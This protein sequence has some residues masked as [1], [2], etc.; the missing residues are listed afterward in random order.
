MA[1]AETQLY[2]RFYTLCKRYELTQI[3]GLPLPPGIVRAQST[4]SEWNRAES[5]DRGSFLSN[6][7]SGGPGAT[8]DSV[9]AAA[10]SKS[11]DLSSSHSASTWGIDDTDADWQEHG[12]R[13]QRAGSDTS[14]TSVVPNVHAGQT[15]SGEIQVEQEAHGANTTDRNLLTSKSD[16][17]ELTNMDVARPLNSNPKSVS[18]LVKSR[19]RP[20][21]SNAEA[22]SVQQGQAQEHPSEPDTS[23]VDPATAHDDEKVADTTPSRGSGTSH[24]NGSLTTEGVSEAESTEPATA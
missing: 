13:R 23:S 6:P 16:V 15:P 11:A 2:D 19:F 14:V 1:Q 3:D 4:Q 5:F 22:E 18:L 21:I 8:S 9:E 10:P 20:E 24:S 12:T 7:S 17:T